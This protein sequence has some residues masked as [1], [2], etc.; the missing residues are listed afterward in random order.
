MFKGTIHTVVS[1]FSAPLV[2][3]PLA[4]AMHVRVV[5]VPVI[6]AEI[7]LLAAV[8]LLLSATLLVAVTLLFR[9]TLRLRATL[10]LRRALLL[11][12]RSLLNRSRLLLSGPPVVTGRTLPVR[13]RRSTRWDIS[14]AYTVL[15]AMAGSPVPTILSTPLSTVPLLGKAHGCQAQ[16]QQDHK[17]HIFLHD[18]LRLVRR[19]AG[20]N[21]LKIRGQ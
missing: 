12:G 15:I 17:P 3:V 18:C 16:R 20:A 7:A 1:I 14:A 13:R 2:P 21:H 5:G 19:W 11:D 9:A 6:I 10:L 4:I 8:T